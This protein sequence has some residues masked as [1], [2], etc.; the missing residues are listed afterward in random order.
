M[1]EEKY[2]RQL[3]DELQSYGGLNAVEKPLVVSALLLKMQN[4]G[5]SVADRGR[6][7]IEASKTLN[8]VSPELGQTPLEYFKQ[9]LGEHFS[10][11]EGDL[12]SRLYG[13]AYSYAG[14]DGHS[15]GIVLTPEHIAELCSELLELKAGDKVIEPCCGTGR[16]LVTAMK[17]AGDNV[18]G[19]ELQADLHEIARANVLLHGGERSVVTF[20]DFFRE[21]LL[22]Q[23]FTAGFMN[24]PYSQKI[25]ELAFMKRLLEVLE[26]GG[27]AA[28]VVPVSTMIGKTKADKQLKGEILAG[29]TLEGVISLDKETFYGVGTVPCIAVFTVGQPHPKEKLCKFVNFEDDGFEVK[30]HVGLVA[31]GRAEERRQYLLECWRGER[32]DYRTKFMVRSEVEAGDEWLHPFYY[33]NDE[34]PAEQDFARTIADYLTFEADMIFHGR[35]YLFEGGERDAEQQNK[36]AEPRGGGTSEGGQTAEEAPEQLRIVFDE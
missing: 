1:N 5:V 24:P 27:R 4:K 8:T 35:G 33:Y 19:V 11:Y 23:G 16:F 6:K 22:G 34:L 29:H 13:G 36:D 7:I 3:N 10:G 26:P 32:T 2:I 20:G 25:T 28:I 12:L 21:E 14:T 18:H 17:Y 30:K 31:G 9:F 15:L